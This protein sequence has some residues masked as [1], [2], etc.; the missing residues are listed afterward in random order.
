[1]LQENYFIEN[2][3]H[4]PNKYQKKQM[5]KI[6]ICITIFIMSTIN[7][8]YPQNPKYPF[9]QNKSYSVGSIKPQNHPQ[10]ELNKAV[11]QFY[12]VWKNAYI[13]HD[14]SD[15]KQYYVL[16]DEENVKGKGST[17]CVSEGQGYGMQIMVLMAGFDKDARTI[18]NGM[19]KFSRAHPSSKSPHLMSWSILKGCITNTHDG[20]NSSATDGDLDIA[21][22]LLMADNQWGSNS[23]INYRNEALKIL[24]AILKHEINYKNNSVLLSDDNVLGDEDYNDIRSSDFMPAHLRVFNKFYPN[25]EWIKVIDN[26][27]LIFE[28][29]QAEYS[30]KVFLIPDFIEYKSGKYLPAKPNYLESKHDGEYYYNAC[31]VP[32]RLAIDYLIFGDARA[33]KI[34]DPLCDWIQEK[35][36]NNADK[37]CAGYHLNG[38]PIAGRNYAVPAFVCPFTIGSM[39][40]AENQEWLNDCWNSIA[41]FEFKDYKYFDNSIQMLSLLIIS[42][43]FWLPQP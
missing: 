42:G 16:N 8:I 24:T 37:I 27:Y 19:F 14:C 22:S 39:V 18:F 33:K 29:L 32:F 10:T 7:S 31:R 20:N 5:R 23:E 43:N 9:P 41:D 4:N 35:T 17:I 38:E 12:K 2:I 34:L 11:M 13:R 3:N 25:E 30:P 40:N 1:M 6:I 36:V 15:P 28:K 21:L 26:S